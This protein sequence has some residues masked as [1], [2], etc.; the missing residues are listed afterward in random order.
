[1]SDEPAQV[2]DYK[3]S[4]MGGLAPQTI[5]VWMEK[6]ADTAN[7]ICGG[8]K[9]RY[10]RN[11]YVGEIIAPDESIGCVIEAI[12]IHFKDAPELVREIFAAYRAQL[13]VRLG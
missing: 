6:V 13:Q 5:A 12:D 1:L 8:S 11:G 3:D 10:V 7:R 2:K 4:L 9:I